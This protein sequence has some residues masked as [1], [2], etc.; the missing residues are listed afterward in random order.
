MSHC[1]DMV[2]FFK[3]FS[4]VYAVL[5]VVGITGL[6]SVSHPCSSHLVFA[7]TVM[8]SVLE[9]SVKSF[10]ARSQRVYSNVSDVVFSSETS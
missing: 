8:L 1:V 6:P 2:Q 5:R 7:F 10:V 4:F 3:L 9:S